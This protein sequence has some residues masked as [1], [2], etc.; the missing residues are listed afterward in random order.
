ML[1][2]IMRAVNWFKN[3]TFPANSY[4]SKFQSNYLFSVRIA[5]DLKLNMTSSGAYDW[6][7]Y[8]LKYLQHFQFV[9]HDFDEFL[10]ERLVISSDIIQQQCWRMEKIMEN[11][12]LAS[13]RAAKAQKKWWKISQTSCNINS[14]YHE[15]EWW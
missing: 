5:V 1:R 11:L 9:Q 15:H 7:I 8:F 2:R 13:R 6:A 3:F 12:F 10:I 14:T 4:T